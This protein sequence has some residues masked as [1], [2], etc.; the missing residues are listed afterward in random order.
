MNAE[1]YLRSGQL[2]EALTSLREAV[3]KSPADAKLRIFLFQLLCVVGS[4]DK[5]LTQL[6]VLGDMDADIEVLESKLTK[7]RNVKQGMMQELLTG[8]IRLV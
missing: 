2:D 4:W 5:A 8:R 3:K 7:A 6:Q 1:D